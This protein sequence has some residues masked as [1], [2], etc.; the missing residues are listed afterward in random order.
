MRHGASSSPPLAPTY[1]QAAPATQKP[2]AEAPPLPLAAGG[3]CS[4]WR[5]GG[6]IKGPVR[7]GGHTGWVT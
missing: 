1:L 7:T 2:K 4:T 3:S 5:R 6:S